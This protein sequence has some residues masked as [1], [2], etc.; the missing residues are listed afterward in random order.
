MTL[1]VDRLFT[2]VDAKNED[3]TRTH[4]QALA[5]RAMSPLVEVSSSISFIEPEILALSREQLNEY[6]EQNRELKL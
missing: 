4:Y 2:Y 5:D 6:M 3:N 1:K